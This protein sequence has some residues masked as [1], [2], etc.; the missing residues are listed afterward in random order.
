M[1]HG[2][3]DERLVHLVLGVIE[4]VWRRHML[5]P[6]EFTV[7][8]ADKLVAEHGVLANGAYMHKEQRFAFALAFERIGQNDKAL[9]AM[10]I[11]V[12]AHEARHAVQHARG[13]DLDA[14]L[15]QWAVGS[16]DYNDS[17]LEIEA[18]TESAEVLAGYFTAPPASWPLGG[19]QYATP[20]HSPYTAMW[21]EAERD[22]V[23]IRTLSW[24]KA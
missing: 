18:H 6:A 22:G 3:R 5:P 16:P 24:K 13:V 2:E 7:E 20:A 21:D 12:A 1:L 19:R 23:R 17:P 10:L 4:M 11:S 15:A 9:E 14:A 8:F